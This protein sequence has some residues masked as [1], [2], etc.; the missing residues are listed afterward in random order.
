MSSNLLQ[1]L[2]LSSSLWS[3]HTLITCRNQTQSGRESG[4]EHTQ[5]G[6]GKTGLLDGAYGSQT[7]SGVRPVRGRKR[8][9]SRQL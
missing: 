7:L 2:R 6:G 3:E 4:K 1:F 9:C 5:M 8:H